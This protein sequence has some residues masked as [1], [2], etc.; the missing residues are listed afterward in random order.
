MMMRDD[1]KYGSPKFLESLKDGIVQSNKY[2]ST[3][4]CFPNVQVV[5]CTNKELDWGTLTHDRWAVYEIF[6]KKGKA[7]FAEWG[8]IFRISP[9][10]FDVFHVNSRKVL[11]R[12]SP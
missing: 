10:F 1:E 4:I 7:E 11:F 5:V 6:G 12:N 8:I 3:S 9:V 2:Q